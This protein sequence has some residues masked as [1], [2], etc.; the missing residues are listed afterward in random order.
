MAK[1]GPDFSCVVDN[2]LALT[3]RIKKDVQKELKN[4]EIVDLAGRIREKVNA[5]LSV[6]DVFAEMT[7]VEAKE[8]VVSLDSMVEVLRQARKQLPPLR[9]QMD[10]QLHRTAR[11]KKIKK[12][13]N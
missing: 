13:A 1:K 8:V 9:L 3:E 4:G 5:I 10:I 7:Y 12:S 6:R 11:K 2:F